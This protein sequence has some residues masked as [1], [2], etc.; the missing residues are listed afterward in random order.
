MAPLN[1]MNSR[2]HENCFK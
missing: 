2:I 1:Y